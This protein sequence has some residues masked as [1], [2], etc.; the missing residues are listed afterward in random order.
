[1]EPNEQGNENV[2]DGVFE[3]VAKTNHELYTSRGQSDKAASDP[4]AT[5]ATGPQNTHPPKQ[6]KDE[7][8]DDEPTGDNADGLDTQDFS[9]LPVPATDEPEVQTTEAPAEEPS[10]ETKTDAVDW[11]ANL[12][13]APEDKEILPPEP[14]ADGKV[15]LEAY[16]DYLEARTEYKSKLNQYNDQ[17]LE[18]AFA[19]VERV[20]PEVK[21]NEGLQK[22][23]RNTL[24]SSNDPQDMVD[25]ANGVRAEIDKVAAESKAAGVNSTKASITIQKNAAVETGATQV[26]PDTSKADNLDKRLKANDD[27]AFE[28]LMD[29]WQEDG[30]V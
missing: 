11:T 5:G 10:Q 17:V 6:T 9:R 22:M 15:D 23:L 30:K 28:E 3:E 26:K 21:D 8:V 18:V 4:A 20:L 7:A 12:P 14:D 13:T 2:P 27:S 19:E 29:Q 24:L 16:A 1:M 25:A